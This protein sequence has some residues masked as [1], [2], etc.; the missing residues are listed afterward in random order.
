MGRNANSKLPA[1]CLSLSILNFRAMGCGRNLHFEPEVDGSPIRYSR[2]AFVCVSRQTKLERTWSSVILG[3]RDEYKRSYHAAPC[4]HLA[5][6]DE[7]GWFDDVA[8]E[9]KANF[10]GQPA[11]LLT[12]AHDRQRQQNS[13]TFSRARSAHYAAGGGVPGNRQCAPAQ[14]ADMSA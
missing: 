11:R 9:G 14:G 1:R 8:V 2:P 3:W 13:L 6:T 12:P 7:L 4:Q 10:L 5:Q